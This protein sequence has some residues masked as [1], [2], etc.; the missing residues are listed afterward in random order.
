MTHKIP[1]VAAGFQKHPRYHLHFTPTIETTV[2]K[3]EN[4]RRMK[5]DGLRVTKPSAVL[6]AWTKV[7]DS[8]KRTRT[9]EYPVLLAGDPVQTE[10][11]IN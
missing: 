8:E 10:G 1:K 6:D 11:N 9:H 3:P 7:D 4:E 5:P 2:D